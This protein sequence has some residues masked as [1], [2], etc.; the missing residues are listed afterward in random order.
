V[1]P[2]EPDQAEA[3]VE[4]LLCERPAEVL[5]DGVEGVAKLVAVAGWADVEAHAI[6]SS[7]A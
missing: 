4:P 5:G 3:A 1:H 2:L 6:F 7:G